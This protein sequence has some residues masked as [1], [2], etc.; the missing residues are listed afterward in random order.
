MNRLIPPQLLILI[1]PGTDTIVTVATT[2]TTAL[3]M[4]GKDGTGVTNAKD[5]STGITN[6]GTTIVGTMIAGIM[7]IGTTIT[8]DMIMEENIVEVG[9]RSARYKT[10]SG[11]TYIKEAV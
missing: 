9:K 6:T 4:K 10:T 2:N 8:E 11:P 3:I 7:I 1:L 5:M